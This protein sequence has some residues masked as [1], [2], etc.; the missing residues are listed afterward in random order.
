MDFPQVLLQHQNICLNIGCVDD[1]YI[2]FG[3][4]HEWDIC[5]M[6][7]I[8]VEAGGKMTGLDG[9]DL[10]YNKK[11][12]LVKGGFIVSNGKKHDELIKVS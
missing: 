8:V 9:S 10:V 7:C 4:V 12:T 1:V 2:R 6:H 3:N 11:D 5:A